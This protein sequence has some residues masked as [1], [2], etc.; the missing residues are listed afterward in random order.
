[1][2]LLLCLLNGFQ[3]L[4][5]V[6]Q[7]VKNITQR[8][9]LSLS[10]YEWLGVWESMGKCLGWWAP[11]VF[12]NLTPEQVQNPDKFI[13]YLEEVCCR[14]G[15]SGKTQ[16]IAMCW[17][18]AHAYRALLPLQGKEGEIKGSQAAAIPGQ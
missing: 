3:V 10:N 9:A 8:S 2:L 11:L 12:L 5:R 14:P 13:E 6:K 4:C 7:L 18:L 16:T 15:N 17:G 1:M